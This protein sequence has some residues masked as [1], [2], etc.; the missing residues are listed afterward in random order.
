MA[1]TA[2]LCRIQAT[3]TG[4]IKWNYLDSHQRWSAVNTQELN[5]GWIERKEQQKPATE[6]RSTALTFLYESSI[7]GSY[8]S[9][10]IPC[11]N[12]TVWKRR[13][14]T[15]WRQIDATR[16]QQRQSEPKP[17]YIYTVYLPLSSPDLCWWRCGGCRVAA[18]PAAFETFSHQL[19]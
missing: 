3:Q 8:F 10:K 4:C 14:S 13:C 12:W 19:M 18:L 16:C 15:R 5:Q 11:T 17:T 6:A 9:T 7:V 2:S 1:A